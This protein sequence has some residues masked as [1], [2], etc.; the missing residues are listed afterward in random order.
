MWS[1]AAAS[2]AV[3]MML[4]LPGP[5][6][7]ALAGVGCAR[8]VVAPQV[9]AAV[10][11]PKAVPPA[12]IRPAAVSVMVKRVA[13]Y[14]ESGG[15]AAPLVC[16]IYTDYE[17]PACAAFYRDV[18][19]VLMKEYVSTGKV[20]VLHRDFPLPQHPYSR[21]AA[22]YAN[23][24]GSLGYYG[25]VADRLF[26]S[27]AEW[28]QNGNVDAALA[29]VLPEAVMRQVR[30]LVESDPAPEQSIADDVSMAVR[31]RIDQTPTIVFVLKGDRQKVAGGGSAEL[32]RRFIDELTARKP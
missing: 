13:N 9:A 12:A 18:F 26:A 28:G 21:V 19:P 20:R 11:T 30:T 23:A 2:V 29:K 4:A 16:E 32:L 10:S 14:K 24:A 31:D 22:R 1:T 5:A 25:K 6:T 8:P 15:A 17:C 7:C 27:Q 3:V